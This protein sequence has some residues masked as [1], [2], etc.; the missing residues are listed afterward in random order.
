T[1]GTI[2]SLVVDAN[3]D[4]YVKTELTA[5]E[6]IVHI[7]ASGSDNLQA[8][9]TASKFVNRKVVLDTDIRLENGAG[10]NTI[11]ISD[12]TSTGAIILR[13][14]GNT[15]LTLDGTNSALI[16]GKRAYFGSVNLGLSDIDGDTKILLEETSNSNTIKMI[17]GGTTALTL[18]ASAIT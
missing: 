5:N 12:S 11:E 9:S 10:T 16:L 6:D 2:G 15:L 4:T 7:A 8:S 18:T 14:A 17:A 3:G 13:A 1:T